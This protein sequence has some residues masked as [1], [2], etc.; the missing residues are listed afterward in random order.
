MRARDLMTRRGGFKQKV[1]RA[2]GLPWPTPVPPWELVHSIQAGIE[3]GAFEQWRLDEALRL[4][5]HYQQ[6]ES[7][8][9]ER[10][11]R[12]REREARRQ[13]R[14]GRFPSAGEL[15]YGKLQR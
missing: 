5:R 1:I 3:A 9:R 6:R 10:D 2:L 7:R 12:R 4:A 14:R 8:R 11:A 13:Q 15:H